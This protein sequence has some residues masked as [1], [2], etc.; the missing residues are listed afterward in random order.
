MT[1]ND[2]ASFPS[3]R[4]LNTNNWAL[5]MNEWALN[6]SNWSSNMSNKFNRVSARH[7]VEDGRPMAVLP[8]FLPQNPEQVRVNAGVAEL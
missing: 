1:P 8:G 6:T 2:W 4:A 5:N 3:Y 7:P